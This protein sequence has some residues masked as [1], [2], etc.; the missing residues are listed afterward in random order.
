MPDQLAH[1]LFGKRV[2]AAADRSLRRRVDP[3]STAFRLGTFGP[4]PLFTDL[5]AS[6]RAEGF[7]LHRQP[8]FVALERMRA[9]VRLSLIHI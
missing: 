3:D 7:G 4:D 5:S 6:H 2:V 1:Y 8:G 9:G